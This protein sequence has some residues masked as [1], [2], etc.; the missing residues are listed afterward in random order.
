M[1]RHNVGC[2]RAEVRKLRPVSEIIASWSYSDRDLEQKLMA[3]APRDTAAAAVLE[4]FYLER[5]FLVTAKRALRAAKIKYG[6]F[7]GE[8]PKVST[9]VDL[10]DEETIVSVTVRTP[11][12]AGSGQ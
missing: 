8:A 4:D 5:D 2:A 10:D 9:D 12:R 3:V 6:Y 1:W 7:P 11:T